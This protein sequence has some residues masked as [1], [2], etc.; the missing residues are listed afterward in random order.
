MSLS[1]ASGRLVG[2]PQLDR[3]RRRR[4]T[5]SRALERPWPVLPLARGNGMRDRIRG[6]GL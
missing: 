5:S 4:R 3:Q 1:P 6:M 2:N